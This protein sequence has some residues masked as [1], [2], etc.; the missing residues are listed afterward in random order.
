M[1]RIT[2]RKRYVVPNQIDKR[3]HLWRFITVMDAICLVPCVGVTYVLYNDIIPQD[4]QFAWRVFFSVLPS[5]IFATILFIRPIKERKNIT[6]FKKL[7]WILDFNKR[8]KV[9]H[10]KKRV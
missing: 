3:T 9:Y 4:F 5:V 7:K 6:M 2:E 1:E 8:Q 10:Y